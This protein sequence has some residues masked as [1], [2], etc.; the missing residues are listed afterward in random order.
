MSQLLDGELSAENAQR[1]QAYLEAHPDATDW[2]ENLDTARDATAPV[3]DTSANP[4]LAVSAIHRAIE[5]KPSRGAAKTTGKRLA[6]PQLL[7]PL[8]AAAAVALVASLTWMGIE[9][10]SDS[11]RFEASVVEFVATDLPDASTYIYSDDESGWTVVWVE[12]DPIETK[13]R[14]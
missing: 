4:S 1:L 8:A 2:M 9:S 12:A 14:G 6:F 10:Q 5:A 3:L 13:S 11:P 7:R